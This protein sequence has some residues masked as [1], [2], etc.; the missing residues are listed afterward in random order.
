MLEEHLVAR[1]EVDYELR[2]GER[3]EGAGR[4]RGPEVLAYLDGEGQGAVFRTEQ[5]VCL[6][7]D[8]LLSGVVY[9][10]AFG[11]QHPRGL[12]PAG[13]VEL[14]AAGKVG[15]GNYS[16]Y[17]PA[18]GGYG[19]VEEP[20]PESYRRAEDEDRRQI[21]S[22][23]QN[24]GYG[25]LRV[26]CQHSLPEQVGAG[27]AR[28]AELRKCYYAG[29]AAAQFSCKRDRLAGV[30]PAVSDMD[31]RHRGRD[32]DE[33]EILHLKSIFCKSRNLMAKNV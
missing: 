26:P 16:E 20:A 17:F 18:A 10:R 9:V 29:S 25:G 32:P 15:L 23:L 8:V 11:R 5:L 19:T 7:G 4:N 14:R 13:L 30:R 22:L 2:S 24:A 1:G 21:R 28:D 27:V 3:G 12:E 31:V 33:S 6:E